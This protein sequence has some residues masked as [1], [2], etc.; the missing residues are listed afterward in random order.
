MPDDEVKNVDMSL[1]GAG[2]L[3]YGLQDIEQV[4]LVLNG[5]SVVDWRRLAFRDLAHVDE[6]LARMGILVSDP[7]DHDRLSF[8]H[9]EAIEYLETRFGADLDP[10]VRNPEDVR[11][12]FLLA[13]RNGPTQ[14]DACVVL[15][16][17]HIIHHVEGRELLYKLPIPVREL[18]HEIETQVYGAID[19]MKASGVRIVEVAASRKTASSVYTK[20][21]CRSDSQAAQIHDRLR[22]RM[23]TERPGDL[24]SA[25]VYMTRRLIPFNYVVPGESQNG[26]IDL[27]ATLG[28]DATLSKLLPLLQEDVHPAGDGPMRVNH[29]SSSGYRVINFVVDMAVRV[30]D[31]V[32]QLPD[33]SPARQGKV[34]FLLAEF[35]LVDVQTHAQNDQGENRHSLYK[36]R[37]RGRAFERLTNG[38]SQFTS[39]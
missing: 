27:T 13:S 34:V 38:H 6:A 30:D 12:L 16:V 4:R 23:V 10:V 26:L 21:L 22:F 3:P 33:H 25:L 5:D 31:L 15:K 19:E 28:G 32:Q 37:Q 39:D 17:M 2:L 9:Q 24:F 7:D 1:S 8:V 20:L 35:Q 36:K 14:R 29:F 11:E 18:F